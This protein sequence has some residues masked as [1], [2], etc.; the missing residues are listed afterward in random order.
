MKQTQEKEKNSLGHKDTYR[1]W[2][3]IMRDLDPDIGD[4][5]YTDH[6]KLYE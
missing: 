2:H 4:Q 5:L 6:Q 1:H 3:Y